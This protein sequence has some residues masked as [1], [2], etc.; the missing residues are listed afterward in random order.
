VITLY[1]TKATI[2]YTIKYNLDGGTNGTNPENYT[3]ESDDITLASPTKD[4]YDFDGWYSDEN[5]TK[6][7]VE[8]KK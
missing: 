4:E 1:A 8:I 2:S 5:F 3:I 6:K 7:I